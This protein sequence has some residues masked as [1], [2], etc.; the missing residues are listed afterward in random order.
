MH[1]PSGTHV[2]RIAMRLFY[3]LMLLAALKNI[4]NSKNQKA[5]TE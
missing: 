1:R 3:R 2:G 4:R 5:P